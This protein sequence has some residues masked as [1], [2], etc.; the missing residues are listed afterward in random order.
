MDEEF[1]MSGPNITHPIDLCE[2]G[3]LSEKGNHDI[4]SFTSDQT[5]TKNL[6]ETRNRKGNHT[7]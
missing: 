1:K 2:I 6:V 7:L 4:A 5:E 3:S